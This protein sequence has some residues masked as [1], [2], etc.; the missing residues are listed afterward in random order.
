MKINYLLPPRS[1]Q[2]VLSFLRTA[3]GSRDVGGVLGI[4]I[5]PA[6]KF[7]CSSV[8]IGYFNHTDIRLPKTFHPKESCILYSG[9]TIE[10]KRKLDNFGM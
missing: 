4:P 6:G 5:Q 2:P 10:N 9:G 7:S 8:L 1:T 3:A